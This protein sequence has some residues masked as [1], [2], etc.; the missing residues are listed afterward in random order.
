MLIKFWQHT[1]YKSSINDISTI[2]IESHTL[3]GMSFYKKGDFNCYIFFN[4][5]CDFCL[6]EIEDIV[7]NI[8]DFKDVNF[9]LISNENESELLEYNE[10]SE[11]LGIENFIILQDKNNLFNEFFN[12]PGNPSTYLYNKDNKLMDFK[13]GFLQYYSLKNMLK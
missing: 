6:N 9:Y 5:N 7:D 12:Y 13:K 1:K 2:N 11:F 10:D 3:K 4:S 8:D